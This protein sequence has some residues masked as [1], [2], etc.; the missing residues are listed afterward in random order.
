M[1]P[2]VLCSPGLRPTEPEEVNVLPST[3]ENCLALY[4]KDV[5]E[6]LEGGTDLPLNGSLEELMAILPHI[7]SV[8]R[9]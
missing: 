2:H 6:V 3:A 1:P 7:G 9:E 8:C 5:G 4:W